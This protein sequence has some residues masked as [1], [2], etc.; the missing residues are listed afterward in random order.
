MLSASVDE[1]TTQVSNG[2]GKTSQWTAVWAKILVSESHGAVGRAGLVPVIDDTSGVWRIFRNSYV[3]HEGAETALDPVKADLLR[4]NVQSLLERYPATIP[5][6]EKLGV[7]VKALVQRKIKTYEDVE[8][9]ANSIFNVGPVASRLPTHVADTQALAYDDLR[10]RVRT[11]QGGVAY[12]VPATPRGTGNSETIDFTTPGR[13]TRF[14]PWHPAS[15]AAFAIQTAAA[16]KVK[17]EEAEKNKRPRGRPRSDGLIPGSK[18]AKQ[19]DEKKH[20]ETIAERKR[21][22]EERRV[23]RAR[24]KQIAT[25]RAAEEP[26]NVIQLR[27]D[28]PAEKTR[29]LRRGTPVRDEEAL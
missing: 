24:L 10:I 23:E 21:L 4:E 25:E 17:K 22:R 7:R 28:P 16:L 3:I 26:D 27:P 19:A 9:W 12:V 18:E 15:K 5:G 2:N 29:R 13:K 20:L 8:A 14:G 11:K 6:L 1:M